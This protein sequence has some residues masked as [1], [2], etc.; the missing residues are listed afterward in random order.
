MKVEVKLSSKFFPDHFIALFI[1]I[2]CHDQKERE[3]ERGRENERER[4][5]ERERVRE[6]ERERESEHKG[7]SF[8]TMLETDR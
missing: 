8:Y 2:Q 6:R 5:K 4:E 1:L 7:L 3:G